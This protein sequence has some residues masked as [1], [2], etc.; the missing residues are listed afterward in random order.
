[1]DRELKAALLKICNMQSP[2]I[3]KLLRDHG[4]GYEADAIARLVS[5]G[6]KLKEGE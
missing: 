6:Q 1:M 4:Y 3:E 5:L 2:S